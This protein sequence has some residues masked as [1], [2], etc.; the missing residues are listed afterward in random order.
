MSLLLEELGRMYRAEFYA[1]RRAA[2][3]DSLR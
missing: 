2:L 1:G 3:R